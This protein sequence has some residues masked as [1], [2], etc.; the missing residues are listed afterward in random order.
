MPFASND[1]SVI[2]NTINKSL[3]RLTPLELGMF[4]ILKSIQILKSGP[5]R[6]KISSYS[7]ETANVYGVSTHLHNAFDDLCHVSHIEEVVGLDRG[8]EESLC[9]RFINLVTAVMAIFTGNCVSVI[10]L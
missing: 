3:N 1:S 4:C 9:R 8:R 2:G 6:V 7:T 10:G 5:N